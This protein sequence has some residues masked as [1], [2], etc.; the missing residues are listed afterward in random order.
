MLLAQSMELKRAGSDDA[1]GFFAD[2]L[3]EQLVD[4]VINVLAL[5][6]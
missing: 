4:R 5:G 6:E 2:E 3:H 1:A